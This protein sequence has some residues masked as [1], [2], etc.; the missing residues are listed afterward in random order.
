MSTEDKEGKKCSFSAQKKLLPASHFPFPFIQTVI[1]SLVKGKAT[2][3]TE[4]T[5]SAKLSSH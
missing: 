4:N 2:L 3:S 5:V 1:R